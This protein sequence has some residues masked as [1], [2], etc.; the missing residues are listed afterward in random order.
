M[1]KLTVALALLATAQSS[2]AWGQFEQ[3]IATGLA[4]A[5][6]YNRLTQ[7]SIIVQQPVYTLPAPNPYPM[8]QPGYT[9]RPVLC[10]TIPVFDNLGRTVALQQVCD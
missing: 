7:P 9:P 6:I 5:W 2:L 1:R 3:G 10:R 4:G 8:L